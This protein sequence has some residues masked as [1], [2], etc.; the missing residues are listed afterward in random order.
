VASETYKRAKEQAMAGYLD[1]GPHHLNCAQTVLRC[2]LLAMDQDPEL[3]Y[4]A[5]FLGGGMARMG[6]VCGA[7]S[8]AAVTLGL[9]EHLQAERGLKSPVSSFDWLQQLVRDFEEKTGSTACRGLLGCDISTAEG[10][11]EAK[12]TQ[13]TKDC[14]QFVSWTCDR[15]AEILDRP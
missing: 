3:T 7:L 1:P 11:R 14:P 10:F 2:G 5:T 4:Y 15:L 6:L 8:G 12:K 13:A 9:Y